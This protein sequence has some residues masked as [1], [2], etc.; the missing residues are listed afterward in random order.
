MEPGH[1]ALAHL[2]EGQHGLFTTGQAAQLGVGPLGLARLVADGTLQHP[3][4][5]LYGWTAQTPTEATARHTQLAFGAHLLYD[6]AVLTGVTAVLAHGVTQWGSDL[7][8]PH[9]LRPV[10]RAIGV[11][12][13]HIRPARSAAVP[14]AFG[15]AVPV[16]DALVQ[17]AIDDGV[18]PGVVSADHALHLGLVELEV[19]TDAVS[20]VATW[21]GASRA[22]SMLAWVDARSESVGESRCRV[23][24]AAHGIR[25]VPQ[26]RISD[27][28]GTVVAR[29]DFVVEGT[30]VIVEFDGRTKYAAGDPGVLWAEKRREDRLR[31][32]GY[33][34]VR[35]TWADLE[36]PGRAAA[37][38]RQALRAA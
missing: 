27:D 28:G 13:F 9:I 23:D 11:R 14:T 10:D 36:H 12:A 15:P 35:I 37:K 24:L 31:R 4:R 22:R 21:P 33:V 18:V 19:L 8:R 7:G 2:A 6:D 30:K 17:H 34:V 25:L 5:G 3:A 29:V 1:L 26:V 16:E 32:L 38:V 20:R